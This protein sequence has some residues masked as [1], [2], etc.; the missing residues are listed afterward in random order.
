MKNYNI[1]IL[2][3]ILLLASLTLFSCKKK[4]SLST[5]DS[6]IQ[7]HDTIIIN[8][9][10]KYFLNINNSEIIDFFQPI[11]NKLINEEIY[12]QVLYEK[13]NIILNLEIGNNANYYEDIYISK[14][15]PLIIEKIVSTTIIKNTST[16]EKLECIEIIN[17]PL[18]N[19]SKYKPSKSKDKKCE[20]T[21][22]ASNDLPKNEIFQLI[23]CENSRFS[24]RLNDNNYEILDKG[25]IISKGSMQGEIKKEAQKIKLGKID[26]IF[27][28]DS[29]VIENYK[30]SDIKNAHF[31]QCNSQYLIFEKR[32]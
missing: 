5:N 11:K 28:K 23:S 22:I 24:I 9:S 20:Q 12:A 7:K 16:P 6:I 14:S 15:P 8:I 4:F 32:Q 1:R 27:Y 3:F 18:N 26:A 17:E 13:D 2:Q 30:N 19:T 10:D 31:T 21:I 29:L 25:K